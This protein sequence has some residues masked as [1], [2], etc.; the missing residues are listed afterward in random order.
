MGVSGQ[1]W[2]VE[3]F[4]ASWRPMRRRKMGDIKRETGRYGD[5]VMGR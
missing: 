3:E 4:I 1:R 2:R 5:G